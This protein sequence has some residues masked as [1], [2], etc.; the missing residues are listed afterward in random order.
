MKVII[1]KKA[2]FCM[3]VRRAVDMTLDM[4]NH[5]ENEKISTFGPLI[6]NPQVLE[7]LRDKGVSVLKTIPQHAS[8]TVIIR[9]HGVPPASKEKL[10]QSGLF[11]KDATCPRVV[12]VQVIINKHKK[13][14]KKTVIIGDRNHAEVEG[15]LGYAGPDSIV[16]SSEK[17]AA[18]LSLSKPYIIVSQT[19]QDEII[20]ENI[21][22]I[23]TQNNTDGEVF[24]TI[25][26][27]THKR[28]NEV[29]NLCKE[30]EALVVVGGKNS[31]N[32]KR[33]G[34]IAQEQ[35]KKVFVVETE[36][37]LNPN[38]FKQYKTVGVTAG[39]STPNWM[40][41]RVVSSLEAIPSRGEGI[42][43]AMMH[44]ALWALMASNIYISLAGGVLAYAC[45]LLQGIKPEFEYGF[46]AFGY[47]F[48]MH[49]LNRL[50]DKRS[51]V[52][53]DPAL[54]TFSLKY[55]S[56]LIYLSCFALFLSLFLSYNENGTAFCLLLI[57][58]IFG[59]LY[60]V[61]FV[62]KFLVPLIKI[63]R[64]KE[65]P[66]SKTMFV[67]LA[68]SFALVVLPAVYVSDGISPINI[69]VFI[70][71][72]L[73]TFVRNAT[74]DVFEVQ[75]DRIAGK[76]TLP[77]WLGELG[78]LRT[79]YITMAIL[80]FMLIVGPLAGVLPR[81]FFYAIPGIVYFL[82]LTY[83]YERGK[84][85]NGIKLEFGLDTALLFVGLSVMVAA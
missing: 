51:R 39:A 33:L 78:A 42:G 64:L 63:S 12:K 53:N 22:R 7:V 70:F 26:D 36:D 84:L 55:R 83:M 23:I 10:E 85:R 72:Y 20:F 71:I 5:N 80:V 34:M 68:W 43:G 54:H 74:F 65:I 8:G 45:C 30:V 69:F 61:K 19:T 28:Q 21:V 47:L 31:A 67:S 75:G 41:N 44:D 15:L 49:N 1:A 16:V 27:S 48:A 81:L 76:E 57:M 35:G 2:G 24:N 13:L 66:A 37:E 9:A 18:R 3:G 40:I 38:D 11:V 29:R 17:E 79:L 73:L 60:R 52:F 77:V 50:T 14:G 25:C 58:T 82:I 4:V 56:L 46:I 32:T 59:L 62:P 6:H